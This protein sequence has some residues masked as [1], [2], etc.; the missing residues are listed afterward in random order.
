MLYHYIYIYI[1]YIGVPDIAT[2]AMV[3][4]LH[5]TLHLPIY[6]LA[7]CNPYGVVVLQTYFRGSAKNEM[8]GGDRYHVPIQW[9]G[10]RPSQL[11]GENAFVDSRLS[12]SLPR[13]VYQKLT[14][15]DLKKIDSFLR[16]HNSNS[17][18]GVNEVRGMEMELMKENGWKVELESLHWLGMDF[19]CQWLQDILLRNLDGNRHDDLSVEASRDRSE[20]E[21]DDDDDDSTSNASDDGLFDPRIAI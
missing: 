8:D 18:I 20:E 7:D 21:E 2:R 11:I 17:F 3:Y 9:V 12:K 5:H 15:L 1:N 13:E 19:M 14:E 16:D 6:G 10:L 4:C